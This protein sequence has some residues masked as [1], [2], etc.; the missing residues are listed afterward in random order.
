[1]LAHK[2]QGSDILRRGQECGSSLVDNEVKCLLVLYLGSLGCESYNSIVLSKLK[3][4][5]EAGGATG[6][7][8]HSVMEMHDNLSVCSLNSNYLSSTYL[9]AHNCDPSWR[10]QFSDLHLSPLF[11]IKYKSEVVRA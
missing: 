3:A 8:C 4:D 9:F 7:Q 1:M 6:S 10:L 5:V 11:L 2:S